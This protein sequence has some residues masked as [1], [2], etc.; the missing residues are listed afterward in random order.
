MFCQAQSIFLKMHVFAP[1]CLKNCQIDSNWHQLYSIVNEL[2]VLIFISSQREKCVDLPGK[3]IIF[4]LWL[5]KKL[6]WV[7]YSAKHE[8]VQF[9][10]GT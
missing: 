8:I 1:R 4:L 10:L 6:W 7:E 2:F 5:L 9:E 3:K